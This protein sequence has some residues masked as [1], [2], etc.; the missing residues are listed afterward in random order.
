MSMTL[1]IRELNNRIAA[2]RI[3]IPAFQR[4]FVWEKDRV[5]YFV[6]SLYKNYPFGSLLFWRTANQLK[7]ER[8]LGPYELPEVEPKIPIDYVLDGQQ[9]LTTIFSVFQTE[10]NRAHEADW[11]DVY[12]DFEATK[13][14][15]E[16][17]FVA[18]S[19]GDVE[20]G[21]HFPLRTIFDPVGF[22]RATEGLG[23]RQIEIIENLNSNFKEI[24][25]PIQLFETEDRT[26]VAIVFERV[27]RLGLEL[28]TLQLL[29][30]WTW[31]E[32][33]DLQT[34]FR[35]LRESLA[36]YGFS[37][38]GE[39][40]N[41]VLRCAAAILKSD[42]S[43]ESLIGLT[44]SDVRSRFPL[45]ENGI[46][47]AIDFLRTQLGVETL[48]NLP[49][50]TLLVPLS[51]FFAEPDGKQVRY[52][53]ETYSAIH[54]WFW[55]SCF[56]GRYSGQTIRSARADIIAMHAL[57]EGKSSDLGN[58][59]SIIG[60]EY[61]K[62]SVF[63][64]NSAATKAFVLLLTQK[65][66]KSF[67]SG[68]YVQMGEVLQNY[69][70]SEFHHLFPK[71]F[72]AES[73][74]P[75]AL[76]NCLANFCVLSRSENNQIGGARPSVYKS[77]MPGEVTDILASAVCPNSLFSDDFGKFIDERSEMLAAEA[78]RLMQFSV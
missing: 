51:V 27:N 2:G 75:D 7:R 53:D 57:K 39:D 9:R 28:D 41:L 50:P 19:E 8:N 10:L 76:V 14:A 78:N 37:D 46:R 30:A 35:D 33:F 31:S 68:A 72:L 55:R 69:N 36:S 59:T 20:K 52:R 23:E 66:P 60:S 65:K 15:Q 25:I 5:A 74:T 49:Y 58:F 70:R 47:G 12:F 64:V 16:S 56:S 38:V 6:D 17:Q 67:I 77:L 32:D 42:P 71:K 3:R 45:V 34:R 40:A 18:L 1:S 43:A 73:N 61:F 24:Q 54:R 21:R 13:D 26:N 63:R 22:R 11:A 62:D 4:G 29:T 44:G 48:E